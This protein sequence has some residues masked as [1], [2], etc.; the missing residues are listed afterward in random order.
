MQ[1]ALTVQQCSV[2]VCVCVCVCVYDSVM[3]DCD[4][5]DCGQSGSSVHWNVNQ[6]NRKIFKHGFFY[7]LRVPIKRHYQ[8]LYYQTTVPLGKKKER[9]RVGDFQ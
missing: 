7:N 5:M 6:Q 1:Q 9:I 4:P 2:C 3:S 8:I